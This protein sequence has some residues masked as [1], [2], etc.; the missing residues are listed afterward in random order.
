MIMLTEKIIATIGPSSASLD[1][2]EKMI[3]EG[4]SCFRINFSHGNEKMWSESIGLIREAEEK[5]GQ[6]I[7]IMGDLSGPSIRVGDLDKEIT[8]KPGEEGYFVLKDRASGESKEIPIPNKKF[9]EILSEGDTIIMDDGLIKLSIEEVLGNSAKFKAITSAHIKP[10]KS[11]VI[12]Q[13]EVPLPSITERDMK[14]LK[15]VVKSGEID[16]VAASY[17]KSARDIDNL[18]DILKELGIEDIK[19]A[20]KIETRSA[21]EKLEEIVRTS[22]YII[23]ARGDLGMHFPLEKIPYLQSRIVKTSIIMGKPV[24]VATQI[25]A[26]MTK[27]PVPT[28][29]EIVDVVYAIK[30]GVDGFLVTGET[31]I[32]E[33]PV[34]VI[35]WLKKILNTYNVDTEAIRKNITQ[36]LLKHDL[37]QRDRF[38]EGVVNLSESLNAKLVV[39]TKSGGLAKRIAKF[40]PKTSF[41][42][43]SS[44]LKILRQLAIIYGVIPVK[45]TSHEYA[46]GLDETFEKLKK[47]GE[48]CYGDTVVLTYGLI[49]EPSHL[50]K[51]I[52]VL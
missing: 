51:I 17:V 42:A 21:V 3:L 13:K 19:I 9:F 14:A 1:V 4:V 20:A 33:H 39:Y 37:S 8:L 40:R 47:T 35:R 12:F 18:R 26:S 28:R 15:T 45:V 31:A 32:G 44:N 29:S 23:V 48:L 24:Y 11:V 5:T 22:D 41:Y 30:D 27:N 2:L 36:E 6:I 50:V 10:R 16:I 34:E 38:A 7:S 25:L 52:R 46:E 49:E 43:A